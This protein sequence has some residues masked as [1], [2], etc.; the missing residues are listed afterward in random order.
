VVN[1]IIK[2]LIESCSDS[3]ELHKYLKMIEILSS[4]RNLEE[5]VKK[6]EKKE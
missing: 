6:G 3:T 1:T 2:R 5:K 4:N